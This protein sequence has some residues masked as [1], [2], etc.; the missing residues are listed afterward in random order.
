MWVAAFELHSTYTD[1]F[2]MLGFPYGAASDAARLVAWSD[3]HAF[4]GA[5]MLGDGLERLQRRA[6]S[7]PQIS[8]QTAHAIELDANG[9]SVL[10][11]GVNALDCAEVKRDCVV[12]LQNVEDVLFCA[13]LGQL[14]LERGL[15][16]CVTWRQLEK[17][18]RVD[19]NPQPGTLE[20]VAV[21]GE[22]HPHAQNI[23]IAPRGT[24]DGETDP[25]NL[26]FSSSALAERAHASLI[27]GVEVDNAAWQQI[28]RIARRILIPNSTVSREAGAG[29]G[30]DEN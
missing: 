24:R 14:A 29:V 26:R 20:V 12:T 27:D 25:D 7:T 4:R 3:R 13:G 6:F 1:A 2:T 11:A 8:R 18:Y 30:A 15:D 21:H 5:K 10:E 28:V 23:V 19:A 16:I 17:V 9:G 22:T